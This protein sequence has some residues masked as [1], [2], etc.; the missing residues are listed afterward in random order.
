MA[1]KAA[2]TVLLTG[3]DGEAGR[4]SQCLR[5]DATASVTAIDLDEGRPDFGAIPNGDVIVI[6]PR[7][8]QPYAAADRLRQGSPSAQIVFLV[9]SRQ[10]EKFRATLPFV[11]NLSDAWTAA[12]ADPIL[13]TSA[14]IFEA[15]RAARHLV[16]VAQVRDRINAQIALQFPNGEGERRQRHILL[17]EQYM[18]TVLRQ[19]PDPIF[20]LDLDLAILSV[21]DAAAETFG[22]HSDD[23]QGRSAVELFHPSV[24]ADLLAKLPS[25]RAGAGFVRWQ[26]LM[27][28]PAGATRD[29]SV[30]LAPVRDATGAPVG[31]AMITRDVTDIRSAEKSLEER[32]VALEDMVAQRDLLLREV[33]HRVK[34]NLQVVN[35]LAAMEMRRSS[36]EHIKGWLGQLRQRVYTIGLVHQQLMAS[37]DLETIEL[38]A[39]FR[40]LAAKIETTLDEAGR[41]DVSVPEERVK[42]GLDVAVPLG[43]IVTELLGN[44]V[45]HARPL[46]GPAHISLAF[47]RDG[48]N[49]IVTVADNGA[50]DED[51]KSLAA[52]SGTGGRIVR[53]L[54]KQIDGELRAGYDHGARFVLA[55]PIQGG[56]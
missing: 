5:R 28:S 24:R 46:A 8:G 7:T 4:L 6:G 9:D 50:S 38:A 3:L 14:V 19:A 54:A 53:G 36:D 17:S 25:A 35:S 26:T 31:F 13:K 55:F 23:A 12:A 2:Y 20:A 39:F 52:G 32:R 11:P 37:E 18:A 47:H 51:Y 40:E 34:N 1:E 41:L 33:Y 10:L 27:T 15:A 30:S 49:G 43:L 48:E 45:K 29:S 22:F 16:E 42:L 56:D 21:N 44:A